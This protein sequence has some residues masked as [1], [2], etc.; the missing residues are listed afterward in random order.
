MNNF[1]GAGN[2][3]AL[4]AILGNIKLPEI[5]GDY[6]VGI[7]ASSEALLT[8][9]NQL[10]VFV[11]GNMEDTCLATCY[12]L[13]HQLKVQNIPERFRPTMIAAVYMGLQTGCIA[14]TIQTDNRG[15]QLPHLKPDGGW[16]YGIANSW[17]NDIVVPET[18]KVFQAGL[19]EAILT[20]STT[21]ALATKVN[22]YRE[23]HHVGQNREHG[24]TY[25][26]K[27]LNQSFAEWDKA[28]AMTI[29]HRIGHW[30]S[31]RSVLHNMGLRGVTAVTPVVPHTA[32]LSP[33]RDVIVRIQSTP[34]GT[35]RL[36][37]VCAMLDRMLLSPSGAMCPGL[38]DFVGLK[39][40]L[41][42]VRANPARYH[43][44][45]GYL[46]GNRE[47]FQDEDHE[48]LLGR[49]GT[50][51]SV[52][53]PES[54][55][56]KSPHLSSYESK[57]DFTPE[58]RMLCQAFIRAKRLELRRILDQKRRGV[59]RLDPAYELLCA[60][61]GLA[62]NEDILKTIDDVNAAAGGREQGPMDYED[63]V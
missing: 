58:Y 31:T 38:N 63:V 22:W 21:L 43:I 28:A 62:Q 20:A 6:E 12:Y 10:Q 9:E 53:M 34:A 17:A 48:R 41:A 14:G 25:V 2:M 32:Q 29:A 52:Q 7:A 46:C 56:M 16:F 40:K 5:N 37:V 18:T 26:R 36:A 35:A 50:W 1:F 49:T 42:A 30:Y 24:G 55:L 57:E 4:N 39:A 51:G 54:T 33:M 23:N 61:H 59:L 47:N 15:A 60:E 44:G 13:A 8:R 3:N 27:V 19:D 11:M 45:A